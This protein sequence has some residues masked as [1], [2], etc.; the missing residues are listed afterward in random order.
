M[1]PST[2]MVVSN[3]SS[4]GDLLGENSFQSTI[5]KG[6]PYVIHEIAEQCLNTHGTGDAV[7]EKM[8]DFFSPPIK[9]PLN[10]VVTPTTP[11]ITA[12]P[13]DI[14]KSESKRH[15]QWGSNDLIPI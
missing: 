7:T 3:E 6:R 8:E 11:V 14:R 10:V 1:I 15:E 9:A 12:I 5:D 4:Y 13:E 2:H